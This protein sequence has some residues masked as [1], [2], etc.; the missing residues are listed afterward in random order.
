MDIIEEE[1]KSLDIKSYNKLETKYNKELSENKEIMHNKEE[2]ERNKDNKESYENMIDNN[3]I[4]INLDIYRETNITYHL[5]SIDNIELF[6]SMNMKYNRNYRHNIFLDEDGNLTINN[7]KNSFKYEKFIFDAFPLA[8]DML[9]YSI[10]KKEFY[11]IKVKE[12][13]IK[14]ENQLNQKKH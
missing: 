9:L 6:S 11:P 5:I 1:N 3:E 12:D 7:E 4:K 13:I 10:N 14:A 8:N 2:N